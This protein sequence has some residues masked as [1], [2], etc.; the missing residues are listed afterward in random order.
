ME[1]F[2]PP[3][4]AAPPPAE[5]APPPVEVSPPDLS[6]PSQPAPVQVEAEPEI[7]EPPE[8]SIADA[9][10]ESGMD[11]LD[12]VAASESEGEAAGEKL[13]DIDSGR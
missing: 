2:A 9:L 10:D 4:E 1:L 6:P 11:W 13:F 5:A 8:L 3:A 7:E 12:E